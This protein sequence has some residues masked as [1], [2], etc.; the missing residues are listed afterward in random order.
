MLPIKSTL[1]YKPSTKSPDL[2]NPI[3][4]ALYLC[5][6]SLLQEKGT[7]KGKSQAQHGPPST[8]LTPRQ[9]EMKNYGT[10]S[11]ALSTRKCGYLVLL[12]GDL[13]LLF[14]LLYRGRGRPENHVKEDRANPIVP[15]TPSKVVLHVMEPNI[16]HEDVHR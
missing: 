6:T 11:K 1:N 14:F 4:T 7:Q 2:V 12:C 13:A 9:R 16:P 10:P 15:I 3:S 8:L 5:T